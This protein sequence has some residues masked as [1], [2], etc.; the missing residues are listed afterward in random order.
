MILTYKKGRGDKV[1]ISIDGE[2][3]TTV[4]E[5]CVGGLGLVSPMEIDREKFLSLKSQFDSRRAFNYAVNLLSRRAHSE[6]ELTVK[7][8]AKG[9]SGG[10]EQAIEKLKRLGYVDDEHF[11][12]LYV[13]EL[14]RVKKFG[15]R[16][17]EQELYKKGIDRLVA[18]EVLENA[19]FE[20]DGLYDLVKRKYLRYL[21]D[22]KGVKRVVNSLLRLGYSYSEIREALGKINEESEVSYE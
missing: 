1:H 10:A 22:E 20:E 3:F 11:A 15:R 18:E 12:S 4:D 9:L 8:K 17:I 21:G 19:E 13:Q 16:R 6:Y 14:I 5:M 2:Y 7:L